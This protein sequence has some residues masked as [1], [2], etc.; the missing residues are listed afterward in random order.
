MVSV[1]DSIQRFVVVSVVG[2]FVMVSVVAGNNCFNGFR[3]W[4]FS[5]GFCRSRKTFVYGFLPRRFSV[6]G[7]FGFRR[8]LF[9]MVSVAG[10]LVDA[11]VSSILALIERFLFLLCFYDWFPSLVT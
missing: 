9:F 3:R 7:F 1:V 8:W 11:G 4:F 5:Y 10:F 6:V 2:F